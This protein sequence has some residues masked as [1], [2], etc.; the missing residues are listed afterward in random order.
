MGKKLL[1]I[2]LPGF[3]L[4]LFGCGVNKHFFH[5]KILIYSL[6]PVEGSKGPMLNSSYIDFYKDTI[7]KV[8][9][10]FDLFDDPRSLSLLKNSADTALN[11]YTVPNIFPHSG[12]PFKFS[13][14]GTS[15]FINYI[16]K[17]KP[18]TREYFRVSSKDSIRTTTFD[19]LCDTNFSP[20]WV[21]TRFTGRDTVLVIS[22][23]KINCWI[24]SEAYPYEYP[25]LQRSKVIYLDKKSLLPVQ[26][27]NTYYRPDKKDNSVILEETF[28]RRIDSILARPWNTENRKWNYPKCYKR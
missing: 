6:E 15:I 1:T 16:L 2:L 21:D 4:A 24:F 26:I 3:I 13:R 9:Y 5:N 10:P 18:V 11:P 23:R 28:I 12:V 17:G 20:S 19:F 22:E 7:N 8:D 25:P 14:E 27:N